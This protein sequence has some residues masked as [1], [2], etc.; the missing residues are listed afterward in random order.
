MPS[1]FLTSS[2]SSAQQG[3]VRVVSP[4]PSLGRGIWFGWVVAWS[5]LWTALLSPLVVLN[6]AFTPTAKSFNRWMRPWATM[7]LGGIRV[8]QRVIQ[9]GAAPDGPVVYVAN[10]QSSLDIPATSAAIP[11]PFLYLA[12]QD[13]RSW[14]IV[15][16]VL[17]RTAC[18]FIDRDNPRRALESL[19]EAADRVRAGESVLLFPEGGRSYTHG[20]KEFMRGSFVLAIQAGVPVVPVVLVGHTGVVDERIKSARPGE[21]VCVLCDPIPTEGMKRRDAGELCD[22]VRSVVEA[23]MARFS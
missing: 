18:L 21:I 4:E 17:E 10:H 19:K 7:I 6:S 13:L 22:R 15:G 16:W 12:R 5:M 23:E 14:P 9:R 8:R 2:E 20:L 1:A 3:G 11:R